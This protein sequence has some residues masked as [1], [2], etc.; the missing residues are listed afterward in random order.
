MRRQ[1]Y[2]LLLITALTMGLVLVGT[3]VA[4][5]KQGMISVQIGHISAQ[6]YAQKITNGAFANNSYGGGC[7][8]VRSRVQYKTAAGGTGWTLWRDSISA[9]ST[10]APSGTSYFSGQTG[11]TVIIS[12][13]EVSQNQTL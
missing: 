12:G 2:R 1:N 8:A 7:Y 6:Y 4:Q 5:A 3:P 10:Y 11:C 9:A 13:T